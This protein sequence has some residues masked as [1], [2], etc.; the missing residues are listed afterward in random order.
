MRTGETTGTLGWLEAT[1]NMGKT[2]RVKR[3]WPA[4]CG[5]GQDEVN[6][7]EG[8]GGDC[9]ERKTLPSRTAP[10]PLPSRGE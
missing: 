2:F 7:D 6:P 5:E 10:P 4:G 8:P 1:C 3:R 9:S